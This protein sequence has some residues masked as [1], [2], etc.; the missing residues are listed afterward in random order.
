MKLT[1]AT[2]AQP[3]VATKTAKTPRIFKAA[4]DIKISKVIVS[5]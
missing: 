5:V 2:I 1:I 4:N 3:H